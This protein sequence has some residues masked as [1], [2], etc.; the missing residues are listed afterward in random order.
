MRLCAAAGDAAHSLLISAPDYKRLGSKTVPKAGATG[1][2]V[3]DYEL[4]IKIRGDVT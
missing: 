2:F 3:Y 1:I 4:I